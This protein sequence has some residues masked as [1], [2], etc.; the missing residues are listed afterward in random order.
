MKLQFFSY[1][2]F[3]AI[4]VEVDENCPCMF[5]QLF[6]QYFKNIVPIPIFKTS[7][8]LFTSFQVLDIQIIKLLTVCFNL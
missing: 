1:Y 3:P 5:H 6:K 2:I 8:N 7:Y 4:L